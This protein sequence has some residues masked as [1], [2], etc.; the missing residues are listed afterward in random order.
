MSKFCGN[1][2]AQMED[3]AVVCGNC[4]CSMS[5]NQPNFKPSD[6]EKAKANKKKIKM[7]IGVGVAVLAVVLVI[8]I[9]VNFIGGRSYK[10]TVDTYI[11]SSIKE[12][13]AAT[14]LELFP[15]E[16]LSKAL[17]DE[18]MS[19]TEGIEKLQD[20]L[21]RAVEY[22]EDYCD[23]WSVTWEIT[24]EVDALKSEVK[25]LS[26]DCDD[27]FDFSVSAKKDVTVEMNVEVTTDGKTD[28]R[29]QEI[30]LTLIKSGKSWYLWGINGSSI[31]SLF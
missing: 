23:D 7:A 20:S 31:D 21:D 1:C 9:C 2:G 13:D 29:T 4:G 27:E 11:E 3:S 28:T 16:L 17:R 25:Y 10:S 14:V 6:P 18:N 19:R 22:I 8:V 15:D 24:D 30:D 26:E 12:P 5:D